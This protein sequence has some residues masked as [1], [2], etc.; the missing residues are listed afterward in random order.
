MAW[1]NDPLRLYHGTTGLFADAIHTSGIDL[2]KCRLLSDFGRGFY[3]TPNLAQAKEH[4]NT[5][6]GRRAALARASWSTE[7][8][9]QCAAYLEYTVDR[10]VLAAA[11]HLAF[12]SPNRD[13][14]E[15]VQHCRQTGAPHIPHTA[16]NYD[17]VYGPLQGPHGPLPRDR[18]QASFHSSTSVAMLTFVQVVKGRPNL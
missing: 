17:V 2:A 16:Q 15:F 18:E 9:P 13:W 1:G 14:E 3:T 6:Y 4:A 5:L 8:N 10:T 12:V 11:T 7:P